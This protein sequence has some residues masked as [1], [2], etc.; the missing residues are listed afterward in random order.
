[1]IKRQEN[2]HYQ[3]LLDIYNKKLKKI[4]IRLLN[5]KKNKKIDFNY[6]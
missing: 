5:K 2:K 6:K 3:K 1:M 4:K